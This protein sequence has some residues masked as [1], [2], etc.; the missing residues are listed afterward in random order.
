MKKLFLPFIAMCVF[1][2]SCNNDDSVTT[3]PELKLNLNGLENLGAN[4]K[5]EG[6]LIVNG[7]PISTG[8]FTV[9][10]N[11]VLSKTTFDVDATNLST[12]TKF[13]L[14]IEPTTDPNSAPSD[15]KYLVADF[16]GNTAIVST[17]IIGDF[18]MASGKYFLATPT[19]GNANPESGIWF[20]DDSSGSAMTGL[21][22]PT[23]GAGWKYEGWVVSNGMPLSTG[24][25]SNPNGSDEAAPY[26]GTMMAPPFPGEDFLMNAPT[27]LTF[28]GNLSGATTVISIEPEPDNSPMPFTL[29]PLSGNIANPAQT[30]VTLPMVRSLISFP[31]GSVTR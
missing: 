3:Q 25:F 31:S 13:V 16:L 20:L 11:G 5:Y 30:G 7:N 29:K 26:S 19:N 21:N 14:T 9:D 2:N 24:R 28:P 10:D 27:G 18:S 1:I 8:V 17:G 23:L 6:W 12:A 4:Y 15:S 22:L